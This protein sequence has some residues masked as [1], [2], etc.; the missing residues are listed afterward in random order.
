MSVIEIEGLAIE[1]ANIEIHRFVREH[2]G[3][4]KSWASEMGMNYTTFLAKANPN[5]HD[6]NFSFE[7]IQMFVAVTG[8]L[9]LFEIVLAPFRVILCSLD[10]SGSDLFSLH[11]ASE[12]EHADVTHVAN[13]AW[14]DRKLEP[15]EID[16]ILKEKFEARQADDAE[17]AALI[18]A[19]EAGKVVHL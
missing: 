13:Q 3:H 14:R 5:R 1:E 19:K 15:H 17:I 2:R 8:H 9:R 4:A 16:Q 10:D 11:L 7:E 6:V 18:K 12:S